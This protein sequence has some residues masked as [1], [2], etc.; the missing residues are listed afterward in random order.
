MDSL[1]IASTMYVELLVVY[2]LLMDSLISNIVDALTYPK[3]ILMFA[4]TK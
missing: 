3:D 2:F 1:L 4:G